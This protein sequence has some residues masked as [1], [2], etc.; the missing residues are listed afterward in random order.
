MIYFVSAVLV[1]VVVVVV[2]FLEL[3]PDYERNVLIRMAELNNLKRKPFE[4]NRKF[5]N[6]IVD[7]IENRRGKTW[8]N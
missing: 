3:I 8:E 1:F 5:R 2:G 6:R 4:T 7:V